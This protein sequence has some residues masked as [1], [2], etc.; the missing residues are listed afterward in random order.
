[1]INLD[2]VKLLE[3]KVA[4]TI[5]FVDKISKENA[6]LLRRESEL[7]EKL[8]T[9]Q[10]RIN[11]LEVLLKGFK[12]EQGR[13]EDGI[14][15]ALDRLSQFEE[16]IEKSMKDKPQ[17]KP[18]KDAIKSPSHNP[19]Q[20]KPAKEELFSNDDGSGGQLDIGA[21]NENICFEIA[22]N[23]TT[24]DIIDPLNETPDE[25]AGDGNPPAKGKEQPIF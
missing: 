23:E 16:A 15:S 8:E 9:Y 18:V 20:K 21:F 12:D 10:R 2:Q 19:P 6:A 3:A 7:H 22:D 4:K 13:I 11:E 17:G 25:V 14:L 24:D 5:D 1:M